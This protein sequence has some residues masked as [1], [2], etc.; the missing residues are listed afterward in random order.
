MRPVLSRLKRLE[1][2]QPAHII[3]E[4]AINGKVERMTAVEFVAGVIVNIT[5]HLEVWDYSALP[6]NLMG[7]ICLPFTAIWLALSF[8]AILVSRLMR[9]FIFEEPLPEL[10]LL[11]RQR[12]T[13]L[14]QS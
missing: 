5:M 1:A 13:A 6:L 14:E 2:L 10:R 12:R 9:H 11:P 8:P 7:Q 3:L 4:T